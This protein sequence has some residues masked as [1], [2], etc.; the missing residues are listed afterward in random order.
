ML[1]QISPLTT[2]CRLL[3]VLIVSSLTSYIYFQFPT[4]SS[5][6]PGL[7]FPILSHSNLL[8]QGASLPLLFLAS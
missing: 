3:V 2:T 4:P 5:I 6:L 7:L 8:F 1:Y